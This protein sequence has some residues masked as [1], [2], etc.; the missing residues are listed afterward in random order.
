MLDSC[1]AFLAPHPCSG[2]G[3]EGTLLCHSCKN[4]ILNEPFSRCIACGKP[5]VETKGICAICRVPYERAWCVAERRDQLKQLISNFKFMNA[6]A[7]YRPL[8]DLLHEYLPELPENTVVI[9]VPTIN[10]HIRQRGYDHMLL[11]ARQFAR[12]RRLPLDTSLQRA[13]MTEQVSANR[14]QRIDQAK[15]AFSCI[16]QLDPSK[17]YLLLD[18][19]VTTGATI[20]Y[21]AKTLKAS[22][23]HTIWVASLSRQPVDE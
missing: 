12:L 2:C 16:K 11:I 20:K 23:A 17:I 21:A 1:L 5:C 10:P 13:V 6:K 18:D 8:A 15:L 14:K 3:F 4:D 9:P 7:A 22:G 19:V